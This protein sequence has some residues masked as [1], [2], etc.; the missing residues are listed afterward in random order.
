MELCAVMK[1]E[2]SN[3]ISIDKISKTLKIEWYNQQIEAGYF[4]QK[5]PIVDLNVFLFN[6]LDVKDF[7]I[8]LGFV[9]NTPK[10]VL[11]LIDYKNFHHVIKFKNVT[12]VLYNPK[13]ELVI[14]ESKNT[15][16]YSQL[17][18]S[19]E[20]LFDL[21]SNDPISNYEN[22]WLV[23]MGENLGLIEFKRD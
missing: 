23:V 8:R 11:L 2:I 14:F 19:R 1:P 5:E 7:E 10:E 9:T 6:L 18:V 15:E 12:N 22:S 20:G 13:L 4:D 16:F 21:S 17:S 3:E